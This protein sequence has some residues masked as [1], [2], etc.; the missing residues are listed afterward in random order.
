MFVTE[1]PTLSQIRAW[2]TEHLI[3]AADH[4]TDTADRWDRVAV[5]VW[6]ESHG[7]DWEGVAPDALIER[8]ST[9]K[10]TMSGKADRLREAVK[11]DG[12]AP[13]PVPPAPP[14]P[15]LGELQ[16]QIHDQQ[17]QIDDI[18]TQLQP[19]LGGLGVAAVTGCGGG[20]LVAS[21]TGIGA[22]PTCMVTGGLAG[23][24]YLLGKIWE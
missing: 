1:L 20:T 19:T 3:E 10:A 9:D 21:E 23:I 5:Q 7:L 2:D 8:T 11:Q 14:A 4:W 12:P 24:G 15:D 16:R 22:I 6:Q 17:R 13:T 18:R